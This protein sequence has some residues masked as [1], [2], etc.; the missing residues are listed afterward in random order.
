MRSEYKEVFFS[1]QLE[2][3]ILSKIMR[4][5]VEVVNASIHKVKLI[6][7]F[8]FVSEGVVSIIKLSKA[9]LIVEEFHVRW[10]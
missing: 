6:H 10:A 2:L 3:K 1:D 7:E 8:D 4:V 9:I 5:S